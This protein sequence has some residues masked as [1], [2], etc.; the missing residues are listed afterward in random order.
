MIPMWPKNLELARNA[1]NWATKASA[2]KCA[3]AILCEEYTTA[4]NN[5]P[6]E[7]TPTTCRGFQLWSRRLAVALPALVCLG[8]AIELKLKALLVQADPNVIPAKESLPNTFSTHNLVRLADFAHMDLVDDESE[9]L[10][11]LTNY[12]MW[13]RYPT[14]K[15][16][17]HYVE[18]HEVG[19]SHHPD[20]AFDPNDMAIPLFR[21]I[22][23]LNKEYENRRVNAQSNNDLEAP[24]N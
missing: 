7:G 10:K 20:I 24:D 17:E 4:Q 5:V 22:E 16:P 15:K 8:Y 12:I 1:D 18:A 3:A 14:T 23:R 21:F 19:Y 2:F 11:Q 13:G 6:S 9:F